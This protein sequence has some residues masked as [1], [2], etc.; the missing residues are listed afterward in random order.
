MPTVAV[1]DA[2]AQMPVGDE[3]P[4]EAARRV[5]LFVVGCLAKRHEVTVRLRA[6]SFT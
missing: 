2:N 5:G 4:P 3:V 6:T 1:E